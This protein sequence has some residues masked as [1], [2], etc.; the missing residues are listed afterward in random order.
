MIDESY[1][2]VK[3]P[4]TRHSG[5]GSN[6]PVLCSGTPSFILTDALTILSLLWLLQSLQS[7]LIL[8][9]LKLQPLYHPARTQLLYQLCY[10]RGGEKSMCGLTKGGVLVFF[11]SD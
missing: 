4:L 10:C 7:L 5:S 1:H 6:A 11:K 8:S 3:N 9:G 2:T